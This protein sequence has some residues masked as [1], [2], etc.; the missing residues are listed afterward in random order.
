MAL[1]PFPLVVPVF[2]T[3]GLELSAH[4]AEAVKANEA[5]S[6]TYLVQFVQSLNKYQVVETIP[7]PY[8][9]MFT[10][11]KNG[12]ATNNTYIAMYYLLCAIAIQRF[13]EAILHSRNTDNHDTNMEMA[14]KLVLYAQRIL[15]SVGYRCDPSVDSP[16]TAGNF[17]LIFY[18]IDR[19][20][21]SIEQEGDLHRSTRTCARL[22]KN[23][24]ALE[25]CCPPLWK[26]WVVST[27]ARVFKQV[28]LNM[29]HM[30]DVSPVMTDMTRDLKEKAQALAEIESLMTYYCSGEWEGTP[31]PDNHHLLDKARS[32]LRNYKM[33]LGYY[34]P[35]HTDQ[36]RT[37]EKLT[38]VQFDPLKPVPVPTILE[39][40]PAFRTFEPYM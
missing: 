9:F 19:D 21:A 2:D 1:P 8:R 34:R 26:K 13:N 7:V 10:G 15:S 23:I 20:L 12:A 32:L 35:L 33:E 31:F 24:K 6:A 28:A 16:I 27:R 29:A 37:G 14:A 39:L 36:I 30:I 5:N 11:W 3:D 18:D 38:G 25:T 40:F 22:Y 17:F 4:V